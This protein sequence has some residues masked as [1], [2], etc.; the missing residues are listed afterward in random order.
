[1][2]FTYVLRSVKNGDFYIGS[3]E[4]VMERLALHN[5][6]RV[7]S[8]KAYRPWELMEYREFATRGE[9]VR[10]ERFLKA[11]QQKEILKRRYKA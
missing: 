6:G 9:T 2:Y 8:T 10:M 7:K 1:M 4:N 5:T 3:A 11:H